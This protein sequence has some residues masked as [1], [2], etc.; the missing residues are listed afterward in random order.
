MSRLRLPIVLFLLAIVI[1]LFMPACKALDQQESIPTPI[2]TAITAAG[3]VAAPITGGI[4][5]L[6]A[7]II[8]AAGNGFLAI[9]RGLSS[10]KKGKQ[11]KTVSKE[12]RQAE[13]RTASVTNA[14]VQIVKAIEAVKKSNSGIVNFQNDDTKVVLK[15]IMGPDATA[16]VSI[17]KAKS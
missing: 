4:S 6:A 5:A 16:F 3:V 13:D 7:T 9:N 14:A 12:A 10:Y 8:I 1:V 11:L 2:Q 17:A 15:N